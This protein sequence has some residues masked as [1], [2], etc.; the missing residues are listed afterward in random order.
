MGENDKL[1]GSGYNETFVGRGGDDLIWG[2]GEEGAEAWDIW[3]TGDEVEYQGNQSRY[4]I[5]SEQTD[6]NSDG[7]SSTWD[8]RYATTAWSAWLSENSLASNI[9][10]KYFTVTDSL[11]KLYGGDGVDT[12]V[13]VEKIRF[14]IETYFL[15]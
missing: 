8:N 9:A 6:T 7:D 2:R 12:L 10:P 1:Y 11:S 5:S 4:T 13:D 3:N 15:E 14:K